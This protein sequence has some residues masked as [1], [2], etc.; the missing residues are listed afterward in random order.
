VQHQ[1]ADGVG[2]FV[3]TPP[4]VFVTERVQTGSNLPSVVVEQPFPNAVQK[5]GPEGSIHGAE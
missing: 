1:I 2:L 5:L 3:R 4:H